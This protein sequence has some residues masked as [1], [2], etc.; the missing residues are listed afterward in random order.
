MTTDPV[1]LKW[2]CAPHA[3]KKVGD[4]W[5]PSCVVHNCIEQIDSPTL[6]GRTARCGC[7]KTRPSSLD[8]AFFE[9]MGDGSP[10]ATE[11]CKCGA[12]ERLHLPHWEAKIKVVRRWYKI[13]RS[14]SIATED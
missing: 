9:Y 4:Q 10:T 11:K 5:V 2:G 12:I 1:M 13:E 6:D 7:G 8:L 14:E 3:R